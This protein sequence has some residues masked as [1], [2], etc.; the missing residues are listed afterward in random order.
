MKCNKC[1]EEGHSAVW[2]P[3]WREGSTV[4]SYRD[5]PKMV[6]NEGVPNVP[7]SVPNRTES[8]RVG[9]WKKRNAEKVRTYQRDYMRRVRGTPG[10]G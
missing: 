7:N 10:G 6:V 2:C 9:E 1:G 8:A 5:E 3:E 4:S